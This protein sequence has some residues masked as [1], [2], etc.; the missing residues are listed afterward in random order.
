M[1][2]DRREFFKFGASQ[3]IDVVT[4]TVADKL[5]E[6][7]INWIRPPFALAESDFV[8][9][10]TLCDECI[11]ACPYDVLFKMRD[12]GSPA[13][14]LSN[15]GCHMC[16]EWPCVTACEPGALLKNAE[17]L[18]AVPKFAVVTINEE[19]CLPY[20]GPECGACN[21]T[22]PVPNALQWVGA[23]PVIDPDACTGCALCR[24]ACI[25]EP[26][27]ILVRPTG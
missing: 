1:V 13:M 5:S 16:S 8:T 21:D 2:M 24:E 19:T 11:K 6:L 3:A 26:N 14:D 9:S 27:S 17:N 7:D 18:A 12:D 25:T 22:C 4:E 10:C 23:R 20:Q 15:R